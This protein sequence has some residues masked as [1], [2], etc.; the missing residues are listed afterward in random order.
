MRIQ[1]YEFEI[2]P[3]DS[4][5]EATVAYNTA[6]ENDADITS[7]FVIHLPFTTTWIVRIFKGAEVSYL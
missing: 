4:C 3:F 2:T 7:G 5:G 6:R 1:G